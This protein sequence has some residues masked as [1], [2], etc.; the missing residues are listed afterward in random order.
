MDLKESPLPRR[1]R[2]V[3]YNVQH[4]VP[5]SPEEAPVALCV[6]QMDGT[7]SDMS[8]GGKVA[9]MVVR[10]STHDLSIGATVRL[11]FRRCGEEL[12]LVNYGYKFMTS[13]ETT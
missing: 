10:E 1:G 12:G 6:A 13:S 9:A 7:R 4:I 8:Y 5:V 2:V 3:T 11:V